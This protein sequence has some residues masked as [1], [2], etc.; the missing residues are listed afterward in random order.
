V[1]RGCTEGKDLIIKLHPP[2][3]KLED[4]S[5]Q[6]E[7]RKGDLLYGFT[8]KARSIMI[9]ELTGRFFTE[10]PSNTRLVQIWMS[11][12]YPAEKW[13]PSAWHVTAKALY[14][15]MLR[16]AVKIVGMPTR[17]SPRKQQKTSAAS[18]SLVRN[19]SD[20]EDDGP[21][22]TA[23]NDVV[24]DEAERWEQLDK[25]IIREFRDDEGIVNE[26]ALLYH[27]RSAFPLHYAVFK[28]TAS[29]LPH[30]GNSEQL[31][32]RSG[33][34]SDSNGKMDPTRLA[35]WTSVGV[36]YSTYQPSAQQILELYLRKFSKGAAA[37]SIHNDDDIGLVLK[38]GDEGE[39]D[40]AYYVQQ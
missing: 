4:R 26:F 25:K 37:S 40:G 31:F 18:S 10:R 13:L 36:N 34:L 14:L 38:D 24:T 19:E 33:A 17:S 35:V 6:V 12:Q 28:Q 30:E 1:H 16:D 20:D 8:D 5:R 27:V 22:T 23:H 39:K 3:A 9:D 7:T 2:T 21:T 29:H 11:K 32:S 15:G